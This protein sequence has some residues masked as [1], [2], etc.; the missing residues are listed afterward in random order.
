MQRKLE[1]VGGGGGKEAESA[2][3]GNALGIRKGGDASRVKEVR[4]PQA[5]IC[6]HELRTKCAGTPLERRTLTETIKA[7]ATGP[8][9]SDFAVTGELSTRGASAGL[10]G[11]WRLQDS[12]IHAAEPFTGRPRHMQILALQNR[13]VV[14]QWSRLFGVTTGLMRSC[15]CTH[16]RASQSR[17]D[18]SFQ[19]QKR[20]RLPSG[21]ISC[22]ADTRLRA[23]NLGLSTPRSACCQRSPDGGGCDGE[24]PES[25]EIAK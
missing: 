14:R 25:G 5:E 9:S 13:A 10:S 8:G 17:K 19:L 12:R 1:A 16:R 4:Y 22:P 21:S 20:P 24:R 2:K 15:H 6:S 3:P 7:P 11:A 23:S 18:T